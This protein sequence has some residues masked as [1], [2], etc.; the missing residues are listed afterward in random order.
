MNRCLIQ[1]PQTAAYH[2]ARS[3]VCCCL[4]ATQM[5]YQTTV[6]KS[7]RLQWNFDVLLWWFEANK[8]ET[9]AVLFCGQPSHFKESQ[10]KIVSGTAQIENVKTTKYLALH[11]D[12]HS[13]FET[14]T[15]HIIKKVNQRTRLL[16]KIRNSITEKWAKYLYLTFIQ[17][18]YAYC[19]FRYGGCNRTQTKKLQVSQNSALGAIK[20]APYKAGLPDN[21]TQRRI[22]NRTKSN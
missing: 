2:R 11:L 5:T 4:C 6:M 17:T 3:W 20:R 12:S 18:V 10:L 7:A 13:T 9:W 8:L 14:H 1:S 22:V 19:D 15:D 21:Y 16:W